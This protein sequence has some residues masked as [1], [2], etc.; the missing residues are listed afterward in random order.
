MAVYQIGTVSERLG[1]TMDTLRY[2]EKI[3][4]LPRVP[5]NASGLRVYND[6]DISRLQFI[7][8]ARKM[9]FTLVEIGELLKVRESPRKARSKARDITRQK[10]N[11]IEVRFADLKALRRELRLLLNLCRKSKGACPIIE[12][13]GKSD[14]FSKHQGN[15][16]ATTGKRQ[17]G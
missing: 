6:K 14:S 3:G 15:Q 11:E 2:Y 16:R 7:Q 1:L 10:L 4:L 13:F 5:R 17:Q 12:D 9:N 8:R